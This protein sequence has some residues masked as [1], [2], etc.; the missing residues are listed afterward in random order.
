MTCSSVGVPHQFVNRFITRCVGI[1]AGAK[2]RS[3]AL[4]EADNIVVLVVLGGVE[5]QVLDNVGNLGSSTANGM[6]RE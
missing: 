5:S 1:L 6:T 3:D 4:K 2:L